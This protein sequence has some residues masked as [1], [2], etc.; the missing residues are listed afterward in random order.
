M[1]SSQLF[2][3]IED[4]RSGG[5]WKVS[6]HGYSYIVSPEA[7]MADELFAWQWKRSESSG[8]HLHV[9]A[10]HDTVGHLDKVHVPTSRIA[11][12]QVCLFLIR[13]CGVIPA[14]G[15]PAEGILLEVLDRFTRY[16]TWAGAGPAPAVK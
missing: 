2:R 13:Q 10:S 9:S 12:E 8:P 3:V 11:F 15:E 14:K 6:T 7:A 4:K 5:T 16:R 1:T